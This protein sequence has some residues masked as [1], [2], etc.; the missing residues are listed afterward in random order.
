MH[1]LRDGV[2]L[3]LAA[4]IEPLACAI[5]GYNLLP[6]RMGKH[7]LIYGDGT[8]GL[9]MAQLAPRAGAATVTI[10]DRDPSQ[11]AVAEEVGVELHATSAEETRRPGGWD[12]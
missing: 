12:T 8:M 10:I 5:R 2:D 9:L 3:E 7:Y 4:L 11:L 1:R 6:R